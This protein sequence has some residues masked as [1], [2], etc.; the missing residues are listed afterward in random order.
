MTASPDAFSV[1]AVGQWLGKNSSK[2]KVSRLTKELVHHSALAVGQG[3]GPIRL[4]YVPFLRAALLALLHK[5][6]AGTAE[7]GVAPVSRCTVWWDCSFRSQ[8]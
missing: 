6:A 7:G 3:F 5:A 4:D 2:G 1:V 8:H